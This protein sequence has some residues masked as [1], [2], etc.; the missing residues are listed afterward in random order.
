MQDEQEHK[1]FRDNI[2]A[3]ELGALGAQDAALLEAHLK[4]C[5]SCR[6]ELAAYRKVGDNLLLALPPQAPPAAL[7]QRLQ[8]HL[9]SARKVDRPRWNWSFG[10]LAMGLAL[11]LLLAMNLLSFI[12]LQ[13]IQHQQAQLARQSQTSQ[14]ALAMLA[15][16]G[17]QTIPI[18]ANGITGSLLL[19][20]DRNIA[21][22][23]AWNLPQ[24]KNNQTYQAWFTDQK[25]ERTSAAIF[26]PEPDLPFTSVSIIP[27]N[28]LSNFTGLGVTIEPA[29]GSKLPTGPRLFKIDF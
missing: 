19:D 16:P 23:I 13:S 5:A 9:P 26:N 4:T 22:L 8:R 14:I 27:P 21:V 28:D 10:Q 15:Y 18:D 12:Q 29:G 6:N 1:P 25:G 17:V 7:R 2:P 3:Y 20:K 11:V 24:L